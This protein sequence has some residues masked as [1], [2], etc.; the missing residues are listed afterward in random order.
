MTVKEMIK[1]VNKYN[2]LSEEFNCGSKAVLVCNI[3][4]ADVHPVESWKEF[5]KHVNNEYIPCVAQAILE[6]DRYEFSGDT[7]IEVVDGWGYKFT[8]EVTFWTEV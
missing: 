7:T 4:W 2:E 8:E 5:K 6:C 1:K 3:G